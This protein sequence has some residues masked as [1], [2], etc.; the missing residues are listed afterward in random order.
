MSQ[1]CSIINKHDSRSLTD[2]RPSDNIVNL[3]MTQNNISDSYALKDLLQHNG[4]SFRK[5]NTAFY[6]GETSCGQSNVVIPDPFGNDAKWKA[7]KS[8]LNK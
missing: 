5:L 8:S 6:L 3:I 7:Y 1:N 4:T 2:Y